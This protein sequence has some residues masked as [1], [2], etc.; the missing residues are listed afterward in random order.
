[1]LRNVVL[2]RGH[3]LRGSLDDLKVFFY[4]LAQPPGA[5]AY[6]VVGR[7]V[8]GEVLLAA[9]HASAVAL[10]LAPPGFLIA[11]AGRPLPASAFLF[12]ELG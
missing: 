4:N 8:R 9:G 11:L 10:A 2:P 1:M 7:L 5:A 3:V 12:L 6:N